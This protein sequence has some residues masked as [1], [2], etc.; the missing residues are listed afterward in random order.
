MDVSVDCAQEQSVTSLHDEPVR[1]PDGLT[2]LGLEILFGHVTVWVRT[3]QGRLRFKS[4][5]VH[6]LGSAQDRH[7]HGGLAHPWHGLTRASLQTFGCWIAILLALSVGAF[8]ASGWSNGG[9]SADPSNP[10]Y[11]THDWI[12]QHALDWLPAE[13][14]A[15]I[16]SNL[17]AYMYGTELPDNGGAPDG[18]GDQTLHHVYYHVFGTLEDDASA[19]RASEEYA[20]TLAYLRV[21]NYPMAA[22]TAG[23]LSHYV[24]DIAVFGHVMGASTDWGA[25]VHHSDYEDY[26]T[27]RMTSY[28]SSEFDPFLVFDGVLERVSAYDATLRVA[29]NTTFGDGGVTK[30]CTWMDANYDWTDPVFRDSAG[31]SLN[32]AVNALADMLHALAVDAPSPPDRTVPTIAILSPPDGAVLDPG[33]V[34]VT[35]SA[36]D[37]VAVERVEARNDTGPWTLCSGT[38]S[39]SCTVLVGPGTATIYARATD[40]AGNSNMT[41][42][43]VTVRSPGTPAGPPGPPDPLPYALAAA[44]AALV[45][46]LAGFGLWQRRKRQG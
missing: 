7:F 12:A 17:A 9:Y 11:G 45:S 32:R 3:D 22:K 20:H 46:L 41:A 8:R 24:V 34:T 16:T 15:Y 25:E 23:I 30:S 4:V 6:Y 29:V 37:N 35:G 42:I 18:I 1:I 5:R 38:T 14:K 40:A 43:R 26:V 31:A 39:W 28:A 36:S 10:D 21:S 27:A 13:E 19:V 2:T 44:A 33:T